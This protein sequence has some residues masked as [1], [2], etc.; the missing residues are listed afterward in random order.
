MY[1]PACKSVAGCKCRQAPWGLLDIAGHSTEVEVNKRCL[2]EG[3]N[4]TDT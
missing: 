4:N 3:A 2:R 1:E